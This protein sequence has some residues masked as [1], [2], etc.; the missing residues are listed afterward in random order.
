MP[1]KPRHSLEVFDR[2][3]DRAFAP[4]PGPGPGP[5]PLPNALSLAGESAS[6]RAQAELP[7]SPTTAFFSPVDPG[8][9]V[10]VQDDAALELE[11]VW[12]EVRRH[13][14]RALAGAPSKV[15]SLGGG[16]GGG[17]TAGPGQGEDAHSPTNT[18]VPSPTGEEKMHV[19]VGLGLGLG[20][21]AGE[22]GRKRLAN[23]RSSADRVP[24][25]CSV[26]FRESTD[27]R[28]MAI[29]FDLTGVKKQDMHVS[30]RANRLIVSWR[31]DKLAERH[32]AG[33]LVREREVRK[34][35]HTIPLPDG[36]KFD[37]V[38][39]SRDGPRLTLT[40]PNMRCTRA[41]AEESERPP[42]TQNMPDIDAAL[43]AVTEFHSC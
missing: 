32:E 7:P 43:S 34:Y 41:D 35:S 42:S 5:G 18:L 20:P 26:N 2:L 33:V 21:A 30:Y 3:L 13:K 10:P 24:G 25:L 40:V 4:R 37:E 9:P 17:W 36:T 29:T 15:K 8:S 23:R 28:N 39:A 38:R 14:A 1:R 12:E 6:A 22:K 16:G 31:L 27:G 19:H 11:A